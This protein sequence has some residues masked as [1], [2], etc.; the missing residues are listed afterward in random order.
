MMLS[1]IFPTRFECGVLNGKI[2]PGQS[3][4]IAGAGPID[5]ATL[6][7]ARLY[8]SAEIILIDMDEHRLNVGKQL[9]ATHILN[10]Q[11]DNIIEKV[12]SCRLTRFSGRHP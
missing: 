9:G 8:S 3:V 4:A 1:D 10:G 11:S 5:L 7:T 12:I 6:L 2:Q